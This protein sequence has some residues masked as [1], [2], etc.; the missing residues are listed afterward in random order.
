MDGQE[1]KV[2]RLI[3]SLYGLKQ[4]PKKWHEKFDNTLTTTGFTIYESDTCVYYQY[5]GGE[6]VMLCLYVDG[7]L[8]FGSNLNVIEEVKS[9][10]RAI[11]K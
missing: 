8:I 3:K 11:S 5:G 7:I 6:F 2:C 10:Y 1:N 4:A 9:F